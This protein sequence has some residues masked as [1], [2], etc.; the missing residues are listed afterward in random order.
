MCQIYILKFNFILEYLKSIKS[1][2]LGK[3]KLKMWRETTE[4]TLCC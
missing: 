4:S 1:S 2:V 3:T